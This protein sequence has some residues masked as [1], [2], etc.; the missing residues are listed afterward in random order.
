MTPREARKSTLS[1]SESPA[2]YFEEILEREATAARPRTLPRRLSQVPLLLTLL[3]VAISLTAWNLIGTT[4]NLDS[5][6]A[7][8]EEVATRFTLYLIVQTLELYR[9]STGTL[10]TELEVLNV[11]EEGV[12]YAVSGNAYE[13]RAKVGEREIVY[14][15]GEDMSELARAYELLSRNQIQ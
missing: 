7:G 1:A 4:G 3:A 11:N 14:R 6:R 5:L 8:E 13:L 10:P 9:D 15:S 2:Q 12:Q